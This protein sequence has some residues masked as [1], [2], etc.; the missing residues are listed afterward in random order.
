MTGALIVTI[1]IDGLTL[2][3]SSLIYSDASGLNR[4]PAGYYR[5]GTVSR[6]WSGT[7]FG[8]TYAC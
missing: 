3:G 8:A 5:I 2:L 6:Y 4:A 1:Y 7:M